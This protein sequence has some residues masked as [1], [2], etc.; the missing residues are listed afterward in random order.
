ML[1][2]PVITTNI[3]GPIHWSGYIVGLFLLD[4]TLNV[5]VS[6]LSVLLLRCVSPGLVPAFLNQ[7]N[8]IGGLIGASSFSLISL[9]AIFEW[10]TI[11]V[12]GQAFGFLLFVLA[13]VTHREAF[14][15]VRSLARVSP[16]AA[17]EVVG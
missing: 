17:D 13:Q 7:V 1:A 6:S 2:W 11:A 5:Q 16:F 15:E 4:V 14:A 12:C 10:R 3:L 9:S 8:F